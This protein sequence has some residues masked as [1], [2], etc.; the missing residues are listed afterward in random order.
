[1]LRCPNPD[2]AHIQ[3]QVAALA[4]YRIRLIPVLARAEYFTRA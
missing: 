2:A 4:D 3:V 1:M